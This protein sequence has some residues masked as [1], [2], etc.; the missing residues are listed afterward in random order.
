MRLGRLHT[1]NR[2]DMCDVRAPLRVRA[3]QRTN[4]AKKVEAYFVEFA[5]LCARKVDRGH[6][7]RPVG[8]LVHSRSQSEKR[9]RV[10]MKHLG[11]DVAMW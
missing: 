9:S 8:R 11:P 10:T 3:M 6:Q 1:R 5:N 7:E 4:L 2:A